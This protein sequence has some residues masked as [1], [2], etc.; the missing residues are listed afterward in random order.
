MSGDP[1]V[2]EV[3]EHCAD[4]HDTKQVDYGSEAD[5]F[6]NVRGAAD[7]GIEPWIGAL[8]RAGDKVKRLQQFVKKGTLANEGV[9]D[10]F[11]DLIVY[12]AI[13]KVL[14]VESIQE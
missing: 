9:L 7:W 1:R 5:P 10:S 6:A 3:F 4:L 12:A 14:Y 13:A 8:V 11:D 2:R